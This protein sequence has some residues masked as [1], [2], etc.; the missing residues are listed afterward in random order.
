MNRDKS[1]ATSRSKGCLALI[2]AIF[3]P[4]ALL[5]VA[6]GFT[7]DRFPKFLVFVSNMKLRVDQKSFI[8]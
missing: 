5:V 3:I 2:G 7:K 1:T 8:E 6:D 4:P